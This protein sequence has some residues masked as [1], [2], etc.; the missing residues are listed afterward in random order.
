[1]VVA[2]A[3]D[4]DG[5]RGMRVGIEGE[6]ETLTFEIAIVTREVGNAIA[7]GTGAI[8]GISDRGAHPSVGRGR[9]REIF[10]TETGTDPP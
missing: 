2:V 5:P 3:G 7:T 10:E 1:M 4:A 8:Q 9:Q 6:T